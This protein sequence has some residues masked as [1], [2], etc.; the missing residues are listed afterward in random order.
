MNHQVPI[1]H[2]QFTNPQF[3]RLDLLRQGGG[4]T[5]FKWHPFLRMRLI[6][7]LM[8]TLKLLH[9]AHSSTS[10]V[11]LPCHRL[12]LPQGIIHI[13]H[14]TISSSSRPSQIT[15]RA[16]RTMPWKTLPMQARPRIGAS[17]IICYTSSSF[18]LD[19]A[20]YHR[21]MAL[22]PTTRVFMLGAMSNVRNTSV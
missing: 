15:H 16:I 2:L 8:G 4:P 5:L 3:V 19:T 10:M 6:K 18:S 22:A 9:G 13:I 11:L 21:A 17:T 12:G 7:Q 1:Y 20:M 14:P